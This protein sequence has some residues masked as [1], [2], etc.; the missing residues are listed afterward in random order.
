MGEPIVSKTPMKP[1]DP[2]TV[3]KIVNTVARL[4]AD[5]G[6]YRSWLAWRL[7]Q[8]AAEEARY[9]GGSAA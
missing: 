9:L 6:P 5:R 3:A 1:R 2:E 4:Q 8:R 7:A